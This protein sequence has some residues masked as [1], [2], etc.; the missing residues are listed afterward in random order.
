[1]PP[2]AKSRSKSVGAKRTVVVPNFCYRVL[3]CGERPWNM[4]VPNWPAIRRLSHRERRNVVVHHVCWGNDAASNPYSIVSLG[5][6]TSVVKIASERKELYGD[7]PEF[8]KI[9]MS[10]IADECLWPINNPQNAMIH[11]HP[12]A[13]RISDRGLVG[14]LSWACHWSALLCTSHFYVLVPH[15]CIRVLFACFCL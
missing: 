12:E 4:R 6:H 13:P 1:M 11:L 5:T 10:Y 8:V 2:R 3:R 15:G 7:K 9:D 14:S